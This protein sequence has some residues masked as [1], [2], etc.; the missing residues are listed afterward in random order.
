MSEVYAVGGPAAAADPPATPIVGKDRYE[1]AVNLAQRFFPAPTSLGFASGSTFPDAP[2][3]TALLA[4]A[5][6][7]LLLTAST[8]L[9]TTVATYVGR[10]KNTVAT[11]QL[12]GGDAA[13]SDG[14]RTDVGRELDR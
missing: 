6:A 2:S 3:G 10:V 1:T 9:P 12:F 4:R 14:V 11:A 8:E 5:G 13:I 7:P